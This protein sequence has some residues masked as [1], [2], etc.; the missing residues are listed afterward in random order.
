MLECRKKTGL[1]IN[2]FLLLSAITIVAT[3]NLLDRIPATVLHTCKETHRA[4]MC[5]V[6]DQV[7]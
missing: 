4:N 3:K 6:M 2:I 7:I 1:V 5:I